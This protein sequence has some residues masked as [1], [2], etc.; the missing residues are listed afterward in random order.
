MDLTADETRKKNSP[1]DVIPL[2]SWSNNERLR[3]P[4]QCYEE[5]RERLDRRAFVGR[6]ER[7]QAVVGGESPVKNRP[8]RPF[9]Q[10]TGRTFRSMTFSGLSSYQREKFRKKLSFFER[11]KKKFLGKKQ[12]T[13]I[14]EETN[15]ANH[16]GSSS[17][18]KN[19]NNIWNLRDLQTKKVDKVSKITS[20]QK[21]RSGSFCSSSSICFDSRANN[22]DP[23]IKQRRS[24]LRVLFDFEACEENDASVRRGELVVVYNKEDR[25]WLW[26]ETSDERQGFVPR[27]YLWPCGC[28][29]R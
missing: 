2:G 5:W 16:F 19:D 9:H 24:R 6:L 21:T 12:K 3:Y 27:S 11:T 22:V 23:F 15:E 26:V 13:G 20:K 25:D 8:F 18:N 4:N 10:G 28:Y 29:G 1:D 7:N 17:D 14:D